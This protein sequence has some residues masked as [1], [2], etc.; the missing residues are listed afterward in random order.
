MLHLLF[1]L[2]T[3]MALARLL[4]CLVA[5]FAWLL[6]CLLGWLSLVNGALGH[7]GLAGWVAGVT[8]PPFESVPATPRI[9]ET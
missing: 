5:W 4:G 7:L 1:A 2:V 6:A 3:E 8:Q 9:G